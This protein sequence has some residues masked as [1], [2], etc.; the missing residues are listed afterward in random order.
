MDEIRIDC[1]WPGAREEIT[2]NF[3]GRAE[4]RALQLQA[5]D[6]GDQDLLHRLQREHRDG[7]LGEMRIQT[8][9]TLRPV[10][11]TT[12][13]AAIRST[14]DVE[15]SLVAYPV[16]WAATVEAR[17][18]SGEPVMLR[19]RP[20]S[21]DAWYRAIDL[22]DNPVP[23]IWHHNKTDFQGVF[24]TLWDAVVDNIGLRC[25][26][27]LRDE[28][29]AHEIMLAGDEGKLGLSVHLAV[30]SSDNTGTTVRGLPLFEMGQGGILEIS[31]L[32][33]ADAADPAALIVMVGGVEARYRRLESALA[34]DVALRKTFGF[35][36]R[37]IPWGIPPWRR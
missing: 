24:G 28:P 21:L 19:L 37:R 23:V 4:N 5:R 29:A 26:L 34:R 17:T 6:R 8:G 14:L 9:S 12:T 7:R 11:K 3:E 32:A 33:R 16:T 10:S 31:L 18:V 1:A 13:P 15:H 27:Q 25:T 30:S 20:D 35:P 2:R 36:E 22:D